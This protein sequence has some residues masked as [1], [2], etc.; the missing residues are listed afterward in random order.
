MLV[1]E[2]DAF[3]EPTY[4]WI[5]INGPIDPTLNINSTVLMFDPVSF[6]DAGIY[7][8]TVTSG[9]FTI[10]SNMSTLTGNLSLDLRNG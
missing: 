2:V 10:S 3:P 4:E 9:N 6:E 1:C 7:V 5:K 8:C